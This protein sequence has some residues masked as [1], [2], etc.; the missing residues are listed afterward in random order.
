MG[1]FLLTVFY[2]LG[3]MDQ[4]TEKHCDL[5]C[6][7]K[8]HCLRDE[9][10]A[11]IPYAC[12]SLSLGFIFLSIIHFIGAATLSEVFLRRGYFILFH[13][14]HYVHI[15]VAVAG[16]SIAFFRFSRRIVLGV[17]TAL[18]VPTCFCI[19]SD[20]ML[21][22]L[23][24]RLLGV[25]MQ[26][27]VCFFELH[28]AINLFAFMLVGL[29]C[30]VALLRNEDSLKTFSLTFHFFHIL[31]SSMASLF[32]MVA[33]G[34]DGWYHSMGIMFFFLFIAVLVPCTLSDVVVP[35]YCARDKGSKR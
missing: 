28:D 30:G 33:Q 10:V 16:A 32:Y 29:L 8:T 13:S 25:D 35:L 18:I 5:C 21:P 17:I 7:R 26:M 24:G 22:T 9:L 31:I 15:V 27:H 34:F 14:F 4:Y 20:I 1:G 23:A 12:I 2:G 3:D 11:H 6:G 19:A